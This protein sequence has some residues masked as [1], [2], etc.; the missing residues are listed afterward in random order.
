MKLR[1]TLALL[2]VATPVVAQER[3]DAT[4]MAK[5]RAE[6]LDRSR[7]AQ[8]FDTIAT[9]IGP[10][11]TGSTAFMRAANYARQK[12]VDFGARDAHLEGWPFGRGWELDRFSVEMVEPRYAPLLGYPEA[13]SPSTSGEVTAAPILIAGKSAADVEKMTAAMN[14]GIVM[15]Q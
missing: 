12:F 2:V 11:L 1:L 3:I 6:G 9:V 4:M 5:I 13:W 7:V 14:G 8:M 15:Q 10:R